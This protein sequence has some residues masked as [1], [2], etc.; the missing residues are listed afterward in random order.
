[1]LGRTRVKEQA[2]GKERRQEQK[3]W[4][5]VLC[6]HLVSLWGG[7]SVTEEKRGVVGGGIRS[8]GASLGGL[9]E[10]RSGRVF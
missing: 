3:R 5:R 2:N 7:I 10:G 1:V 6:K 8:A 9:R 4:K